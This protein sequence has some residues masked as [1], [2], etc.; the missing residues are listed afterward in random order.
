MVR[1]DGVKDGRQRRR[2]LEGVGVCVIGTHGVLSV[3]VMRTEKGQVSVSG[4]CLPPHIHWPQ[5]ESLPAEV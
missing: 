3:L 1:M 5:S 2:N 4:I